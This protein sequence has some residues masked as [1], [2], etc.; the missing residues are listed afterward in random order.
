MIK[1]FLDTSVLLGKVLKRSKNAEKVFVNPN[2]LKYTNEYAIKEI[3]HVLKTLGFSEIHISYA[4]DYIREKCIILPAPKKEEFMS[5]KLRDKADRPIVYSAFKYGFILYI[6]DE[7][8]YHD[9]KKYVEVK[10]I[11]KDTSWLQ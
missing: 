9:A 7:K 11:N 6:D 2:I 10:R 4:I 1:A 5:I 3:Y 8:S